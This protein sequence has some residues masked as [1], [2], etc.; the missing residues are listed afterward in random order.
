MMTE[1][2]CDT[3]CP[4]TGKYAMEAPAE[5]V[6]ESGTL[7]ELGSL[8]LRVTT[9]PPPGAGPL[10]CTMAVQLP[11]PMVDES[12]VRLTKVAAMTMSDTVRVTLPEVAVMVTDVALVTAL[13]VTAKSTEVDHCG[14]VTEA[15]TLATAGLLLESETTMPAAGAG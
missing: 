10:N 5:T 7:A 8:L 14:T 13:V 15:G 12:V 1:V 6:T 11:P 3:L 9:A 4:L 2:G